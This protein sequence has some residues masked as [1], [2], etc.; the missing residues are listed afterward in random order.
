[1]TLTGTLTWNNSTVAWYLEDD[2]GDLNVGFRAYNEAR[3]AAQENDEYWLS[4]TCRWD[5]G[6]NGIV[7]WPFVADDKLDDLRDMLEGEIEGRVE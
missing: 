3:D 4:D 2:D 1:M 7:D 6:A 5:V